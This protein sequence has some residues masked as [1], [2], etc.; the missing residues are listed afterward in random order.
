MDLPSH[1]TIVLKAGVT[2]FTLVFGA[3]F[4]LGPIRI[5]LVVP[6]VGERAA[7][8]LEIPLMLVV[9]FLAAR[10][11]GRHFGVP[12]ATGVRLGIGFLALFLILLCEFT[13]VLQLRGLTLSQYFQTRDPISGTAYYLS[14]GVFALMPW[15]VEKIEG[16]DRAS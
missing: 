11:V 8:L 15:L 6:Q 3:G 13:I 4:L 9:I 5:W 2:Y 14:L 10:W 1:L 16:V 12:T 7:E